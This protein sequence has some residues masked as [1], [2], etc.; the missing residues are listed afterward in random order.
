MHTPHVQPI[1]EIS[2]VMRPRVV[3]SATFPS[4][5]NLL[6]AMTYHTQRQAF[7]TM[8]RLRL[9]NGAKD[10]LPA[11][12]WRPLADEQAVAHAKQGLIDAFQVLAAEQGAL[13]AVLEFRPQASDAEILQQF[14]ASG[15]FDVL[16]GDATKRYAQK[17]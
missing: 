14:M 10:V 7:R 9:P 5:L 3:L 12:P 8:A 2:A 4:G 13:T 15:L 11:T 17:A 6:M 16:T 1:F